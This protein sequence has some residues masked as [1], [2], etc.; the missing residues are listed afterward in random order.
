MFTDC[1]GGRG[2][3]SAS[4]PCW[5]GSGRTR[6]SSA[7]RRSVA[8]Q[9]RITRGR[10]PWPAGLA[11]P[12]LPAPGDHAGGSF[13][14]EQ[15]P[16]ACAGFFAPEHCHFKST[17]LYYLLANDYYAAGRP[18][19]SGDAEAGDERAEAQTQRGGLNGVV[20]WQCSKRGFTSGT[21]LAA[22]TPR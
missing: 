7:M 2:A 3:R 8:V 15:K 6:Y 19:V 12:G 13:A 14:A 16:G 22:G 11:H 4:W 17:V 9:L 1:R 20:M 5:N 21:R 10:R 18:R